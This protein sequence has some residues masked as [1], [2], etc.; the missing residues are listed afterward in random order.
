MANEYVAMGGS[1]IAVYLV[2]R[3][4][5]DALPTSAPAAEALYVTK[6]GWHQGRFLIIYDICGECVTCSV[7][8][9]PENT[10]I[11]VADLR[12]VLEFLFNHG[13]RREDDPIFLV[14]T[15]ENEDGSVKVRTH[16]CERDD[17]LARLAA[18]A[19]DNPWEFEFVARLA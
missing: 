15:D 8:N 2:R 11:D 3:A 14:T 5:A 4:P 12:R 13:K 6:H 17:G 10:K 1:E 16:V 18:L 19:I 7:L 9:M